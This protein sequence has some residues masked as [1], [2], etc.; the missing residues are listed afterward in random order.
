MMTHAWS[1][2]KL[3]CLRSDSAERAWG[4]TLTEVMVSLVVLSVGLLGIAAQSV[5]VIKANSLSDQMTR[6]TV[7]AKDKME[8]LKRLGYTHTQLQDTD[9]S[10]ADVSA[11]ITTYPALFT[12]PDHS[13]T[14][15]N[16]ETG[17]VTLTS[18]PKRVWNVANNTP[19]TGMKTITIIVGWKTNTSGTAAKA[20]YVALTTIIHEYM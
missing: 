7:L 13:D 19:A 1:L 2:R 20:H 5:S 3:A 9:N 18:T 10:T 16:G 12:N 15:P 4:F 8:E 11:D 6:A 17:T 14:N